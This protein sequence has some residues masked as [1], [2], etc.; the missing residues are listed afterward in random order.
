MKTKERVLF[1]SLKLFNRFGEPNVTTLQIAD[2]MNI[3]P[4]NLYYHYK[5]KTEI[6]NELYSR[7][8]TEMFDLL[9][10]PDI[11]ISIEDAWLFL[12]LLFE[13]IARYQFLYKDLVN[14][15]HRY[16]KIKAR[17][18]RMLTRKQSAI[19]AVLGSFEQQDMLQ[20]S[21]T[22]MEALCE[23]VVLSI[24]CWPGYDLIRQ[25]RDDDQIELAKGCYQIMA[26]VAPFLK[27]SER[28]HLQQ[29][30]EAYV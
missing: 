1:V 30:S 9:D 2:E 21:Q 15:L 11:D 23:N 28:A 7:F 29:L 24:T 17:Y 25:G 12:H 20:A 5:N 26:M 6:I 14:I 22:E 8:E 10:V 16:D 13:C 3:S 18:R 27:E 19:A 4:G